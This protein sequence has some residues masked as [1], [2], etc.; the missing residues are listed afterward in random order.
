MCWVAT[1]GAVGFRFAAPNWVVK[2]TFRFGR[3][4]VLRRRCTGSG[5]DWDLLGS[6]AV[7]RLIATIFVVFT[8]LG[9]L[10]FKAAWVDGSVRKVV[11]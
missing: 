4:F 3:G 10:A 7:S 5:L 11:G 9:L 8:A 6:R 2:G 1:Y